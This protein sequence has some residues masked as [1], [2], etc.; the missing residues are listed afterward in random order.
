MTGSNN[1][2]DKVFFY[3]LAGIGYNIDMV[4]KNPRYKVYVLIKG[5]IAFLTSIHHFARMLKDNILY[6]T[7]S[8][9]NQTWFSKRIYV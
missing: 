2:S 8:F 6:F 7:W 3:F 1:K 4:D 9:L 5:C